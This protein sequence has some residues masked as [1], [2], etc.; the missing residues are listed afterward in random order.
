M[1]VNLYDSK[2]VII[3]TTAMH[4]LFKTELRSK[5]QPVE[6]MVKSLLVQFGSRKHAQKLLV[7]AIRAVCRSGGACTYLGRSLTYRGIENL[8]PKIKPLIFANRS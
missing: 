4:K 1:Y 8:L 3:P 7:L 6:D 5:G 2:G